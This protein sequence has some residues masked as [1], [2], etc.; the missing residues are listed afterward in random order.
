VGLL[1]ATAEPPHSKLLRYSVT[2]VV[3]AGLVVFGV[4]WLLRYHTE[5][6]T[7]KNFLDTV[8]AGQ[9]EEAYR[10]WKPSPSY[11]FKDFLDDWGP[12]GYYGPIRSYRIESA[13]R[14]KNGTGVV[15]LAMV[16]PFQPFPA[17]DDD[18]K[19]SKTKEVRLWVEFSD[20][21]LSFPP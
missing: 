1:D 17:S 3:F 21:S 15:V 20:Q 19:Q 10:I 4:W 14:P 9:T 11:S 13:E 8:V 6:Q 18:V 5:K 16:S 2:T 7:V 12:T